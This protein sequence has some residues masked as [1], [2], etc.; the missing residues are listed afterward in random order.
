M[1]RTKRCL[2]A[3]ISLGLCMVLFLTP[4]VSAGKTSVAF[5]LD[6][7][8]HFN[9]SDVLYLIRSIYF[10]DYYA[11]DDNLDYNSDGKVDDSDAKYLLFNYFFPTIY[12]IENCDFSW[13]Q[14]PEP[15]KT[16]LENTTYSEDDYSYSNVLQYV[17]KL[18]FSTHNRPVAFKIGEEQ[19]Y[20]LV[21]GVKTKFNVKGASGT[22]CPLDSVRWIRS[23]DALNVR[24]IGGWECDGGTV[25]YGLLYR[26]SDM[27]PKDVIVLKTELGIKW[28]LNLME[29]ESSRT[30]SV[31]GQDVGFYKPDVFPK[32]TLKNRNMY[33]SLKFV[34]D[35]VAKGEPVYIHCKAGADRTGTMMF[36]LEHLLGMNSGDVDKDY[37]LTNFYTNGIERTRCNPSNYLRLVNELKTYEGE[38]FRDKM[39]TY[40]KSL[41]IT[42]EEI[43]AF[44]AAMIDG[45][46]EMIE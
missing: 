9:T 32:Y 3:I 20:N 45:N 26:G 44:R 38:T 8:A 29:K 19:F 11:T 36:V 41:G 28:E 5:D 23:A 18:V 14:C 16:F 35:A 4:T 21:P 40:V 13:H 39:I 22:L 27:T 34:F 12:K 33:S 2:T 42:A 31:L 37:E 43:N 17:P 6:G 25:K 1:K 24:D 30:E 10:P 46:P 7:S 15:A